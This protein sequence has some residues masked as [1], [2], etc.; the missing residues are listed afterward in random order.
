MAIS[1]PRHHVPKCTSCHKA[2]GVMTGRA[3]CFHDDIYIYTYI[4]IYKIYLYIYINIHVAKQL[5]ESLH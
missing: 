2:I 4:Y 1:D 3:H 5:I